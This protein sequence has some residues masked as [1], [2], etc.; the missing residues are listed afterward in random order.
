MCIKLCFRGREDL[1]VALLLFFKVL[2]I[3][4]DRKSSYNWCCIRLLLCMFDSL[5]LLEKGFS[6]NAFQ[7]VHKQDD[8][9]ICFLYSSWKSVD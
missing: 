6:K 4:C 1:D 3:L 5:S 2:Y 7:K 8:G 9:V